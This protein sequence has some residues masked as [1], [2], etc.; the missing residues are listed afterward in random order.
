[1]ARG[2]SERGILL[3]YSNTNLHTWM[4]LLNII[5]RGS[6]IVYKTR[7]RRVLVIEAVLR[8]VR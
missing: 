1:M 5:R 2:V 8:A 7:T 3:H 4:E 6:G